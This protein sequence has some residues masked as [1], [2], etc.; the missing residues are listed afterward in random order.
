MV[1]TIYIPA[2]IIISPGLQ[3]KSYQIILE[4]MPAVSLVIGKVS[5]DDQFSFFFLISLSPR[6]GL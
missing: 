1:K 4:N 5:S 2:A 3:E 6:K